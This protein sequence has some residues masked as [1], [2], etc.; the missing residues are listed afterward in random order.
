[1]GSAAEPVDSRNP[2][3]VGQVLAFLGV[4]VPGMAIFNFNIIWVVF[5]LGLFLLPVI[6]LIRLAYPGYSARPLQT[7]AEILLAVVAVVMAFVIPTPEKSRSSPWIQLVGP[8]P[9]G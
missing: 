3:R 6:P 1:M 8:P 2:P 9:P 5:S 7:G 4:R